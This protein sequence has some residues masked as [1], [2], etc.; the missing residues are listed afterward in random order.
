MLNSSIQNVEA[1]T[2]KKNGKLFLEGSAIDENGNVPSIRAFLDGVEAESNVFFEEKEKSSDLVVNMGYR[3]PHSCSFI[4]T[5]DYS[6]DVENIEIKACFENSSES[7]VTIDKE[8]RKKIENNNS[9]LGMIEYRFINHGTGLNTIRGWFC[10]LDDHPVYFKVIDSQN[11]NEVVSTYHLT[12]RMDLVEKGILDEKQI[13]SGFEVN[14]IGNDNTKYLLQISTDSCHRNI[15]I[16]DENQ[17]K[18][19]NVVKSI[20]ANLNA[21]TVRKGIDYLK[22]NG[23]GNLFSRLKQGYT[24]HDDYDSWF[25]NQRATNYTLFEQRNKSFSYCPKISIAVPTFNTPADMLRI[26]IDSVLEQS[27]QNWELCISDASDSKHSTRQILKEYQNHDKRIKIAF[28]DN[29]LGIAGNTNK[30]FEIA[31]GE[32]IGLLDHDD[33]LEPDAFYEVVK[34][35]N[36]HPYDCLYTDEDK[37]DSNKQKFISPNFKPDFAIDALRSHNYIT[38]FF[39]ARTELI[40]NV[41]GESERYEGAQDYDLV[42]KCIEKSNAVGHIDRILYHWRIYSGSTAGNPKQKLYCYENGRK[43]IE[44]HLKR[45]NIKATVEQL[46]KPYWGLYRVKYDTGNNPLVSIIIP[47]YENKAVLER[48]ID[49]LLNVNSYRNI[50]ILV[51]ENNSKSKEIFD[52]YESIQ[53]RYENVHVITW[54]GGEFNYSAINNYGVSFAKGEYL[55]LLNNDTQMIASDSI[56]DMLGICMREDV[57]VVGAKLLY[58]DNTVQH[59]GVVVGIGGCAGHVFSRISKDDPGYMMRAVIDYDYSAVTGA[60]LMTKKEYFDSVG[61]LD[62]KLAVAFNDIDYC[63][64]IRKLRK[65]VVYDAFSRW[66]HYE[67]VSRGYEN[68]IDKITRF[69]RELTLFQNRWKGIITNGDPFYNKNMMNEKRRF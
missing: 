41:G 17:I 30:A 39:V 63:L 36:E 32:Y 3:N 61:G 67:S 6:T 50:E 19:T 56:K 51:I 21:E 8:D 13:L 12:T 65:L 53:K 15:A 37:Y 57:G 66:Y 64:K 46:E 18:K 1:I 2:Y 60:C 10:C 45:L 35:L 58:P 69:D 44:D 62:E 25:K 23:I 20:F 68:S 42:L 40:R 55:L 49:S 38:H 54:N 26:M 47:N 24:A 59:A 7:I 9:I 14:F 5:V 43:A 48:C 33:F 27:Y 29:N 16:E 4:C 31:N 11:D 52:Y 28:L 34:L 22:L